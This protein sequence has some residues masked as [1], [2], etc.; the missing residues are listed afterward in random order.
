MVWYKDLSLNNC[1]L[2]HFRAITPWQWKHKERNHRQL[3]GREREIHRELIGNTS[4]FLVA[5]RNWLL[6]IRHDLQAEALFHGPTYIYIY[7]CTT[8]H[9]SSPP[10]DLPHSTYYIYIF[11]LLPW[12]S[13]QFLVIS[14]NY[15]SCNNNQSW[16]CYH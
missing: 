6:V 15:R 5:Q 4:F 11:F 7:V 3:K 12:T 2:C 8:V 10:I 14:I 9:V 1:L 13:A 16:T